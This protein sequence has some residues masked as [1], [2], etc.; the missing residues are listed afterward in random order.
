MNKLAI[1]IRIFCL[2]KQKPRTN[3]KNLNRN[4]ED[5]QSFKDLRSDADYGVEVQFHQCDLE[6]LLTQVLVD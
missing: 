4:G 5:I 6:Q 3:W 2:V 1:N